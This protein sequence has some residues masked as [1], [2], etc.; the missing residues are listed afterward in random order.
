MNEKLNSLKNHIAEINDLMFLIENTTGE[1]Q[2]EA[3]DKVRERV[4]FLMANVD[5]LISDNNDNVKHL[6]EVVNDMFC[7]NR[8]GWENEW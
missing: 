1:N 3:I 8:R 6:Q 5:T 4:K 7:A 2:Q